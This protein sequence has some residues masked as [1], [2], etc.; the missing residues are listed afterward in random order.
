MTNCD[1]NILGV[2]VHAVNIPQVVEEIDGLIQRAG[3]GY[4]TV[5]GVHGI[6]ESQRSVKVRRAH[7]HSFLTV[8][9]GMPLVYIGRWKGFTEMSRCY[10]PD[11]MT[12]VMEESLIK[13]YTHFFYGGKEGVA[14]ELKRIMEQKFPGIQ[15]VGTYTPPFR[16]LNKAEEKQLQQM[17][18]ELKP[19]IFWVG[20]ST[21]KQELFMYHFLPKLDTNVMIGVGAAFDFH[22]G[23]IPM[24]PR[25]MQRMALEWLYRLLSEPKR[26]WKRYFYIVPTFLL[27]FLLQ[28]LGLKKFNN[29]ELI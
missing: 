1:I 17:V 26:L 13:G 2:R 5:T 25:W 24:A 21:P 28:E 7:N 10:G 20:L 27:Y 22:T 11:L 14:E 29:K 3:K 9:D 4:F 15:I 12:A 6:M 23:Q 19:H 8:P 16:P 18:A